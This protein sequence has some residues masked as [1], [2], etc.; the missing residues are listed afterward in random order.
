MNHTWLQTH[1]G[2]AFD[3]LEPRAE[4]VRLDDIALA[5][6]RINRFAGHTHMAGYNV[7]Q[8]S[9]LVMDL[10]PQHCSPHLKLAAL[11]HDAHEAY[12][13]DITTPVS[14]HCLVSSTISW[15]LRFAE[16]TP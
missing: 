14:M 3:L 10:M 9:Y 8:H 12:T 15:G 2:I 6:S 1:S 11:L 13:G 4:D 7:A 5:L 16:W